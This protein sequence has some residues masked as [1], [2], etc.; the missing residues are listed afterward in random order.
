LEYESEAK[1]N[2]GLVLSTQEQSLPTLPSLTPLS[3]SP[4]PPYEMSQQS[5]YPTIIRRLQEQI[6][7]LSEQVAAR[8]GGEAMN[9]E[10]ARP[11]VFDR[12]SLKVSG[13]IIVCKLYRKAKMRGVPVE[14]QIQ[15]ILSYMQGEVADVWKENMLEE[16]EAGEFLAEIKKKFGG[17][18]RR[19]R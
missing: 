17:E 16:L 13:F 10:V 9:L 18:E 1:S 12:T 6:T 2:I 8:E 5:D 3:P 11:Q 19:S 7:T 14:E 15:W 4:P